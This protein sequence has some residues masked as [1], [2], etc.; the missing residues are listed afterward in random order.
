M[1]VK[2]VRVGVG[3]FV[4]TPSGFVLLKRKGSHGEG[5]WS[6]PGGHLDFGETVEDC[7]IRETREEL[8]IKLTN[9]KRIPYWSEDSFPDFQKQYITLYMWGDSMDE[10]SIM[11]PDKASDMMFFTSLA[12]LPDNLFVGTWTA[13]GVL[14][15]TMRNLGYGMGEL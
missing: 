8:G 9:V 12:D 15:I 4:K 3:V 10:P 6:L 11:E 2:Q 13:A 1:T 7:A 14:L 5:E